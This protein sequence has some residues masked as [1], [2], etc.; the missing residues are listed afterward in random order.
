MCSSVCH[1]F[2]PWEGS[3]TVAFT[4]LLLS[5]TIQTV[6]IQ[7]SLGIWI[8]DSLF[9]LNIY[10]WLMK[11]LPRCGECNS[12]CDENPISQ[13]KMLTSHMSLTVSPLSRASLSI[14]PCA[15]IVSSPSPEW[16]PV[17]MTEYIL[18]LLHSHIVLI[19]ATVSAFP[20]CCTK[21]PAHLLPQGPR[22]AGG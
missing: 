10:C 9:S 11:N 22:P 2:C 1:C 16:Q 12:A 13:S 3:R 5:V 14:S 20:G 18:L 8:M 17:N 6:C 15:L 21:T 4:S 19:P 7:L